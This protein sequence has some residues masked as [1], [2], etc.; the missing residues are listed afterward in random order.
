M[1]EHTTLLRDF[2][3]SLNVK[4]LDNFV[5]VCEGYH[6]FKQEQEHCMLLW[7]IGR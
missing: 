6:A 4:L 5:C 1:K 2:K 7:Y 3:A